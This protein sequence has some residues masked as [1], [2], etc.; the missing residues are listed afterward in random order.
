[1]SF[2]GLV[3]STSYSVSVV[4][5][6]G[7]LESGA[8]SGSVTTLV[9]A[10]SAPT[11]LAATAATNSL[12]ATWTAPAGSVTG[13]T[14]TL[15]PGGAT[16]SL[17][18]S[19]TSAT[20]T[21]LTAATTYQVSI[22]ASNAGGTSPP[23]TTNVTTLPSIPGPPSSLT[24]SVTATSLTV[25]WAAPSGAVVSYSVT[26]SPGG[27]S[28]TITA[29]GTSATFTGL[30][31]STSYTASVTATNIA[32][33][34]LAAT[35]TRTTSGVAP[36]AAS[37]LSLAATN[38][39]VT[40]NW[41]APPGSVSGYVVAL[42][43]GGLTQTITSGTTAVF[44]GLTPGSLYAVAVTAYNVAGSGPTVTAS[45]TLPS[46]A[47]GATNPVT[48]IVSSA[49][50]TAV[51]ATWTLP[52][53]VLTSLTV[54]RQPGNIV[55]TLGATAT[56]ATFTGL[57]SGTNYT[58]SVVANGA[59]GASAVATTSAVTNPGN[60]TN[61]VAV[62]SPSSVALSWTA[63]SG[64][65]TGYT[66]YGSP[67]GLQQ[68]V[69]A[70]TTTL[71]FTGLS[72]STAYTF[73]LVAENTGGQASGV[74]KSAMTDSLAPSAPTGLSLSN[75]GSLMSVSWVAASG[76]VSGYVVTINPGGLTQNLG[77]SATSTT[78]SGLTLGATYSVNVV[79]M[80]GAAASTALAGSLTLSTLPSPPATLSAIGGAGSI[81]VN[82]SAPGGSV[83]GYQATLMPGSIVRNL[84]S[85]SLSTVFTGL[86][87]GT[88]YT[89]SVLSIN[90]QG[91][92]SP[93]T[94]TATTTA[95]P[96]TVGP[97]TVTV[98]GS[99]TLGVAWLA[100][101]GV[102]T[103]YTVTAQPGNWTRVVFAPTLS[104]TLSGLTA[105]T[106]YTVSVVAGNAAGSASARTATATTSGSTSTTA[107]PTS[108]PPTEAGQ[109][110]P[111]TPAR[112]L[113]TR[114]AG[115]A[116]GPQQ[117][118][119]MQATGF[120]GL[121]ST[122]VAAVALN[123]TVVSPTNAGFLTLYPDDVARPLAS[124][125]NF[126][127]GDVLANSSVVKV[128]ELGRVAIYNS[129][130]SVHVVIDVVGYFNS[131]G[132]NAGSAFTSMTPTRV[133]DT[134]D[135]GSAIASGA[136]RRVPFAG[137]VGIP[138][139]ASGVVFSLTAVAPTAAGYLTVY[140]SQVARPTASSVNFR[141]GQ[142]IP[143]LVYARLGTDG[144]V[145]IFNYAGRTDVIIDIVGWF[146]SGGGSQPGRFYGLT[147]TR[148]LDTRSGPGVV[149]AI[150]GG[151]TRNVTVG[152]SFGVPLT[153]TAVIANV[154]TV[155]PSAAGYVTVYP[156]RQSRP[157]AST[158]AFPAG[159]VLA[160]AALL[161]LGPDGTLDLYSFSGSTDY[162]I[163]IVG[164]IE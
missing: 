120:G 51:T 100:G 52:A 40:A 10:P 17:A 48:S 116:I 33:T 142:T 59:G 145:E 68:S 148:V 130:G 152:G 136:S 34:S 99:S 114:A 111:L 104:T 76:S 16:Q 14:I 28:Q 107:P 149:G 64:L 151:Q 53:D 133:L 87:D 138:L 157:F 137:T 70:P 57:N 1:M 147:P 29:P 82:W 58:I 75:I 60:V 101:T 45:V 41:T 135:A 67:G 6:N 39:S 27:A 24:G 139:T 94:A 128:S 134:R 69:T 106:T 2:A 63:P 121:P 56:T 31:P 159:A 131:A 123:V 62:T 129:G 160:T 73:T 83:T 55:Q 126:V 77:S 125:I 35:I 98:T 3:S 79:A 141:A 153:A 20:F 89:V 146:G 30:T 22:T 11:S 118:R 84:G 85:S 93:A 49:T 105:G 144:A 54:T 162:V 124:T 115:G 8:A 65:V 154:T 80:N 97:V 150:V 86:A 140:P 112:L 50:S 19:A 21:G 90:A 164:Y 143:N 25:G 78:F 44:S 7:V 158:S 117:V 127:P 163:D 155:T 5:L 47:P 156:G 103:T 13:Y 12:T 42:S 26:L 18:G 92:S 4:A 81:T 32:G 38:T 9:A 72:A 23:A 161:K 122:G 36:Q 37:G 15:S 71:T 96:G 119:T 43:P 108:E 88:T 110:T 46:A 102:P 66:V 74:V 109:F 91:S 61:V 95:V 132:G 113:D